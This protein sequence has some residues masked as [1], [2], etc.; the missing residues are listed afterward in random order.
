MHYTNEKIEQYS[1]PLSESEKKICE[2]TINTFKKILVNNGFTVTRKNFDE[3][4]FDELNHRFHVE[5]DGITFTVFLQGSY[6]NGTCVRQDS[7]VDIAIICESTFISHYKDGIT[8]EKYGFIKSDF[9]IL[10]FKNDLYECLK[11]Y[12]SSYIVENHDKCIFIKGNGT[13]RKNM[14]IVPSLRYRDYKLD[15][16]YDSENYLHGVYIKTN[17]KK[18]IYNYPEQS[19]INSIKKNIDTKYYYK[20]IV[21]IIKNIKMI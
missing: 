7:D 15:D 10:K 20:K 11:N 6:G 9:D 19:R 3:C 5:K 4:D 2:S 13:S 14:D 21:R 16:T 8:G 18:I 17:N 12:N 1:K